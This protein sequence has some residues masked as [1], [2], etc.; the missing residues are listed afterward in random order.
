LKYL[1]KDGIYHILVEADAGEREIDVLRAIVKASFELA[2]QDP[3]APEGIE[4]LSDKDAD[5]FI[6][7]KH[8][9]GDVVVGMDHWQGR[10]C[11]TYLVRISESEFILSNAFQQIRGTPV[12]MLERAKLNLEL[13]MLL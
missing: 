10:W 11:V 9:V 4:T 5:V 7:N 2:P 12:S 6:L 1:I 13:A 8:L 3:D